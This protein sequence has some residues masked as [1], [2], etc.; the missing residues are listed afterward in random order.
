MITNRL[1][2]DTMKYL[3]VRALA[4]PRGPQTGSPAGVVAVREGSKIKALLT[5]GLTPRNSYAYAARG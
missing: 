5:R 1:A 4:R 2:F 3:R